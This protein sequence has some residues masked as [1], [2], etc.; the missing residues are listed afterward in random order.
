MV[1][2]TNIRLEDISVICLIRRVVRDIPIIIAMG[3]IAALLTAATMQL[4]YSPKYTASATVAVN[5]KNSTYTSVYSNLSTT[6]EIA[7]TFTGLF[8]NDVFKELSRDR[9]GSDSLSGTIE[10]VA[11]PETNI[12]RLSVTADDP[13][14]AFTTLRFWLDNYDAVSEHVLQNVVLHELDTPSVPRSASNPMQLTDAMKKAFLLGSLGMVLVILAIAAYSDTVQTTSA[15]RHKVDAKLFATI[16]HEEM[17]KTLRSRLKR[18]KKGL[19][20]NMPTTGFYFTEEIEKLASKVD[21]SARRNEAKVVLIT[22]VAENEGKST[23]AA[24]LALSLAKQGKK[25]LLMDAD[26]HKASQYKLFGRRCT[27]DLSRVLSGFQPMQAEYMEKE[28]FYAMFSIR[29]RAGASELLSTPRL[30]EL[31]EKM[32]EEMDIII[33]DTPPLAMFSDAEILAAESDLSLLVVRQDCV[34]APYINDAVDTLRK[35]NA[36][37]MGCVFNDVRHMSLPSMGHGYGYGYGY[38]YGR[39]YGYGYGAYGGYG[40]YAKEGGRERSAMED[41]NGRTQA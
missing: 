23:V 27:R 15:M 32:R 6:S 19:L 12:L 11:V 31:I 39:K 34:S 40:G 14:A 20:I 21:H 16:H 30:K 22:S 13:V 7:S 33:I 2:E 17:N 25:V 36:H 10:A 41:K 9:E 8:G 37:F 38:G 4:T 3:L 1:K 24:N 18:T 28:R 29:L 5:V 35:C 26:L